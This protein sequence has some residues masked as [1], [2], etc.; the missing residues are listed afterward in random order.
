MYLSAISASL[1]GYILREI[2]W[3]IDCTQS[4]SLIP[5]IGRFGLL[6]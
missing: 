1:D 3:D 6:N 2:D 5:K 4:L